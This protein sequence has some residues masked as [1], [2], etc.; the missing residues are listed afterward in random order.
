MNNNKFSIELERLST[1]IGDLQAS[2]ALYQYI[3]WLNQQ[4]E[5]IDSVYIRDYLPI[6]EASIQH[7]PDKKPFLS[8][9]TRTQGNRPEMIRETLN[10]LE[11]QT[12]ADFELIIVCHKVPDSKYQE[13]LDLISEYPNSFSKRIRCLCLSHGNRTTPLNFGFAHA[14]GKYI[15]VLDD[16]DIVFENYVSCFHEAAT[17]FDGTLLHS[18]VLDQD[19]E[20]IRA[21]DGT[22]KLS[23]LNEPGMKYCVDFDMLTQLETNYCP[24]MG[25]AF[26]S[27]YF[28]K[29][30]MIFDES[31]STQEDWDYIMRLSPIIGVSDIR[32]ATAVYRKWKREQ[33]SYTT[34]TSDEWAEN[35]LNI[36]NKYLNMPILISA[37]HQKVRIVE[38]QIVPPTPSLRILL[39]NKIRRMIPQPL[40]NCL[41]KL[42]R[43]L[44]GK[45]W[46]G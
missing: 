11:T 38:Q 16:D 36:Q 34:H 19:W 22:K 10:S 26:P 28:Q 20:V 42:Y 18:Y 25:I 32:E 39:K 15:S 29:Y 33:T 5:N 1:H 6:I 7:A 30:G 37:G 8:I 13:I 43:I 45:K 44:G 46:L 14:Y 17:H 41:K 12:D 40:W 9:I 23:P 27:I 3:Y 31:L 35:Y 24:L 21:E 4:F 2:T